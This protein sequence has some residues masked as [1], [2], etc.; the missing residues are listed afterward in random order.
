MKSRTHPS[1]QQQGAETETRSELAPWGRRGSSTQSGSLQEKK[2]LL[3]LNA[4]KDCMNV[5][6][7][8]WT[9]FFGGLEAVG[10]F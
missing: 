8:L 9:R 7:D 4:I 6:K 1:K 5:E 3:V 2:H 10:S